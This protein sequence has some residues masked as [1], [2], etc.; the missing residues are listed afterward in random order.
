MSVRA[1]MGM[2]QALE[3]PGICSASFRPPGP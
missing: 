2:V 3:M 1:L